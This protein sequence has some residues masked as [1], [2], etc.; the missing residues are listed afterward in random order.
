[1]HFIIKVEILKI[2]RG[3]QAKKLYTTGR[4]IG[5]YLA[6]QIIRANGGKLWAESEGRGK[7]STFYIELPAKVNNES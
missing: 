7:G 2:E 6:S 4:G 1:L 3:E 5:L